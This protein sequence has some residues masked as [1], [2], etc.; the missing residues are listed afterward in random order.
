MGKTENSHQKYCN[1]YEE[2]VDIDH[3]PVDQAERIQF[4]FP[5]KVIGK[6]NVY[7]RKNYQQHSDY[8]KMYFHWI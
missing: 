3:L 6:D 7:Q 8:L 4:L 2:G 5:L 1:G